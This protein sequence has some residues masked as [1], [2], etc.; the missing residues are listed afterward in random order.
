M[1]VTS[2]LSDDLAQALPPKKEQG[3]ANAID[4]AGS[5]KRIDFF[6]T[7]LGGKGHFEIDAVSLIIEQ[8]GE[9]VSLVRAAQPLSSAGSE[10]LAAG[11]DEVTL[12]R[13]RTKLKFSYFDSKGNELNKW[14][15]GAGLPSGVALRP[16]S[17][18]GII[19]GRP[20]FIFSVVGGS[21]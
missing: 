16:E 2:R 19:M 20:Y 9:I 11:S 7:S 14:E 1:S 3:G 6:R 12:L 10:G 21:Q 18:K 5:T 17:S 4:F 15:S 13:G 8:Q